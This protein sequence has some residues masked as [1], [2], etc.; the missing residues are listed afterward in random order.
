[1]APLGSLV[2]H[3]IVC[4]DSTRYSHQLKE[5]GNIKSVVTQADIDAQK[6]IISCL[7]ATWGDDLLI[8]GEEDVSDESDN[9][10]EVTDDKDNNIL[11][12]DLLDNHNSINDNKCEDNEVDL[13]DLAL[14]VDPLDGTREFV[15][16]R[17]DNVACLIGIAKRGRPIAGVIGLPFP[18]GSGPGCNVEY[19]N[20]NSTDVEIFYA[21]AD[22]YGSMK[23]WRPHSS[24]TPRPSSILPLS[25]SFANKLDG[26]SGV[27]ILTGDSKDPVLVNATTNVKNLSEHDYRHLIVG[28][29]AA[30]LRLVATSTNSIAILHFKTEVRNN[31]SLRSAFWIMRV[32]VE[33]WLIR[34]F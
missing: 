20:G 21:L 24:S 23:I 30:K 9:G 10:V 3:F 18:S 8:I 28:G 1:M 26:Y 19:T 12:L 25:S 33:R 11:D 6:R 32:W 17:L 13:E 31:I 2:S 15:E 4:F 34:T 14:F 22:Q 27:T 7:R 16:G 29:S 5:E